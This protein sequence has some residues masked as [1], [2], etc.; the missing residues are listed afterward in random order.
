MISVSV[1]NCEVLVK[2]WNAIINNHYY[3]IVKASIKIEI[4]YDLL[5]TLCYSSVPIPAFSSLIFHNIYI[6]HKSLPFS[7]SRNNFTFYVC[8]MFLS[9]RAFLVL[10][11]IYIYAGRIKRRLS[12]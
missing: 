10:R 3:V 9:E 8:M 6:N 1:A 11:L 7:V 4:I 2:L 12:S 5:L